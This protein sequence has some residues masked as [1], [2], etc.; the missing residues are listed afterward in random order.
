MKYTKKVSVRGEWAK[1]GTDIKDGDVFKI[2]DEG[3]EV[4]GEFGPRQVFKVQTRNGEKNLSFNQTS[5]NNLIDAFGEEGEQWKDKEIKAW[6]V[7][8]MV[9]DGLK[10]VVYLAAP[11]WD[12]DDEG[13]FH[14]KKMEKSKE[15]DGSSV[16]VPF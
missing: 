14:G 7:K 15:D 2:L 8:Q 9:S 16:N 12:M 5:L 6:V 1:V 11:D 3:Q 10:N 13:H 4:I